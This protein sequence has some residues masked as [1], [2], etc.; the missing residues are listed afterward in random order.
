M[1]AV[2]IMNPFP[3]PSLHVTP[4]GDEAHVNGPRVIVCPYCNVGV[5][6][7]GFERHCWPVH[8]VTVPS[9]FR[10]ADCA[11][12]NVRHKVCVIM[13]EPKLLSISQLMFLEGEKNSVPVAVCGTKVALVA[14]V[15]VVVVVVVDCAADDVLVL[16]LAGR[17]VVVVLA[18]V[19][20]VFVVDGPLE[21]DANSTAPAT[22]TTINTARRTNSSLGIRRA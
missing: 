10:T 18:V 17:D 4:A 12:E 5:P 1:P 20:V 3:L 2:A 9:V 15:V 21:H 13:L 11:G 19:E 8:L 7:P 22:I 16:E 14:D 6:S